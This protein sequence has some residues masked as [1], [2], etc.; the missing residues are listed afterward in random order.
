MDIILEVTH[1]LTSLSIV[2]CRDEQL[3]L[4]LDLPPHS[5]HSLKTLNISLRDSGNTFIRDCDMTSLHTAPN[6]QYVSLQSFQAIRSLFVPLIQLTVLIADIYISMDT[7]YSTLRECMSVTRCLFSVNCALPMT[8]VQR[9]RIVLPNLNDATFKLQTYP[10]HE[11]TLFDPL[12]MPNV[13][14]I[15]I[16]YDDIGQNPLS[17]ASLRSL[18]T[19]SKCPLRKLQLV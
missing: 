4:L 19:R 13:E 6:L 16:E 5:F 12:T 3:H 11:D 10:F 14:S 7:L 17:L 8:S 15:C 18:V 9:D 2:D 1:R